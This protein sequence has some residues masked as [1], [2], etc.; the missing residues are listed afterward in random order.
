MHIATH[1]VFRTVE[2]HEPHVRRLVQDVD[3]GS[4]TVIY[5]RGVGDEPH[6][7]ALQPPEAFVF[8]HLDAGLHANLLGVSRGEGYTQRK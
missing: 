3:R 7:F 6:A 1:A 5:A 8:Q 2:R 4:Q